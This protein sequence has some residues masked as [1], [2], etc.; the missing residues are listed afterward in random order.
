MS[1]DN[2]KKQSG[3][4]MKMLGVT[5]DAQ[6]ALQEKIVKVA[7]HEAADLG[8]G[9]VDIIGA[10]EIAKNRTLMQFSVMMAAKERAEQ[11]DDGGGLVIPTMTSEQQ[12]RLRT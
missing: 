8:L 1:G 3:E 2:G 11:R 6:R 9:M 4:K 12:R 10:L 7:M 5:S